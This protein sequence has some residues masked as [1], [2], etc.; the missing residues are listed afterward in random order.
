M[1]IVVTCNPSKR[2]KVG[3]I[4]KKRVITETSETGIFKKTRF[5]PEVLQPAIDLTDTFDSPQPF[6]M[7]K[8]TVLLQ[9]R[10]VNT[11]NNRSIELP[12][13]VAPTSGNDN[14]VSSQHCLQSSDI[15]NLSQNVI[16]ISNSF[17]ENMVN[18]THHYLIRTLDN[19]TYQMKSSTAY[20]FYIT[21]CAFI[22]ILTG[23]ILALR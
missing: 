10:H 4:S 6:E 12:S 2:Q 5:N 22:V 19:Q 13:T 18:D 11:N 7:P 15:N 16:R 9:D 1:Y 23:V 3:I 20:N 8:P 14:A 21:T 17:G